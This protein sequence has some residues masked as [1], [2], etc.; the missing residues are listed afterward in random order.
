MKHLN[1]TSQLI[2][3]GFEAPSTLCDVAHYSPNGSLHRGGVNK[4]PQIKA[5]SQLVYGK[6]QYALNNQN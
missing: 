2:C 6:Y 3:N 4:N 5:F 1:R